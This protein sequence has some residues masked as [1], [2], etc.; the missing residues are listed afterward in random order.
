MIVTRVVKARILVVDD[1]AAIV[2][3]LS[4][5]LSFEGFT[6]DTAE[7]GEEALTLLRSYQPDLVVLDVMLPDTN[8][9]DLTR[10][11]RDEGVLTPIL[12]LTA[13]DEMDDRVAGLEAGGDDYV[14]KPFALVEIVARI[15]AILRRVSVLERDDDVYRFADLAMDDKAHE[16]RRAGTP[17]ELTATEYSIMRYF[18]MNPR[19][20]LSKSQ[21]LSNV[22]HYDFGG[23]SNIV[24]TH[25]STLRR[26]LDAHGP[27]LIQTKRLVGY[28]LSEPA[29]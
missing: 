11:L 19:Q 17:I 16:L 13:R 8:G 15:N 3:A 1:E 21:I 7:N 25:I 23:D 6:V 18:L 10:R 29:D 24:E 2:D 14:S 12:F 20:V 9:I 5:A 26:K 28:I 4:T 22:W 27:S